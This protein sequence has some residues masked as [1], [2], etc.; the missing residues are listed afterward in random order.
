MTEPTLPSDPLTPTECV[1]M[2]FVATGLSDKQ[3]AREMS[4]SPST[5]TSYVSRAMRKRGW[6]NR[7]VAA[8]EWR[9]IDLSGALDA[10]R[11]VLA[12]FRGDAA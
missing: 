12:Q 10:A 8:L 11:T 1:L 5:V 7:T 4:L 3:I 9:E 6:Q 2:T